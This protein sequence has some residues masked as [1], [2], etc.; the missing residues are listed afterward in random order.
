MIEKA[1]LSSLD[2]NTIANNVFLA[3]VT[4][5]PLGGVKVTKNTSLG[6]VTV[7]NNE[8]TVSTCDVG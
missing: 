8:G 5:I 2:S 6:T 4:H 7:S 1:P 3:I